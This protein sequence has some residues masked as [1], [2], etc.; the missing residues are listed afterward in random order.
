[1]PSYHAVPHFQAG[2][3]VPQGLARL[4][5][6]LL[7][8]V[9]PVLVIVFPLGDV[10]TAR[11]SYGASWLDELISLSSRSHS[12]GRG[13]WALSAAGRGQAIKLRRHRGYRCLISLDNI[14]PTALILNAHPPDDKDP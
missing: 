6:S 11:R 2:L 4:P 10:G 9:R 1:M 7:E 12:Y 13:K 8:V 5:C 3:E 14:L